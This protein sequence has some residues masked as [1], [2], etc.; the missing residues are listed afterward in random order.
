MIKAA[1]NL[2]I[3]SRLKDEKREKDWAVCAEALYWRL[4]FVARQVSDWGPKDRGTV[5]AGQRL[6]SGFLEAWEL[7]C[8]GMS[9]QLYFDDLCLERQCVTDR[10]E[11]CTVGLLPY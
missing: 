7:V 9:R 5:W 6:E 11:C 4:H 2:T 10:G 8:Y 1:P 3:T